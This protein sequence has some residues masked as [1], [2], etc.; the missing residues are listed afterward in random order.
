MSKNNENDIGT[1]ERTKL[2]QLKGKQDFINRF[3]TICNVYGGT[4]TFELIP[5]KNHDL[6]FLIRFH[7]IKLQATNGTILSELLKSKL[8]LLFYNL[9]KKTIIPLR[10]NMQGVTVDEYITLIETLKALVQFT[11]KGTHVPWTHTFYARLSFLL[12]NELEMKVRNKITEITCKVSDYVSNIN[13]QVFCFTHYFIEHPSGFGFDNIITVQIVKPKIVYIST[14]SGFRPA[15]RITW[16]IPGSEFWEATV[17]SGSLHI[18][19]VDYKV[20]IPVYIQS[21]ALHRLAERLDILDTY[22]TQVNVI[23][24]LRAPLFLRVSKYCYLLEYCLSGKKVGYLSC[25]YINNQLLIKTFLFLTN[26]GTPEGKKLFELT[27]LGKLDK[28]YLSLDKMSCYINSDITSNKTIAAF[29]ENAGCNSLIHLDEIISAECLEKSKHSIV[30][31][32][33]NY[34]NK[35]DD[36]LQLL[37]NGE[38]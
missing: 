13:N 10:S 37:Q 17:K 16:H 7:S 23:N 28:K 18:A 5:P 15:Y 9:L 3:K 19:H 22:E 1:T 4:G 24:T 29:F 27:G 12:D 34:I 36:L 35:D 14:H 25:E 26:N 20:P 33:A 8:N 11:K 38:R 2:E 31:V 21:H 30:T 6:I 32:I